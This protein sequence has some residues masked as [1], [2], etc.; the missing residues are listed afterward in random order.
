MERIHI[1]QLKT[2][3]FVAGVIDND[4]QLAIKQCGVV[5]SMEMIHALKSKGILQVV[6]D[7]EKE[8]RQTL[9]TI[10]K[11]E[12]VNV[13]NR[14][15]L[16][17]DLSSIKQLFK[18][19]SDVQRRLVEKV[20]DKKELNVEEIEQVVAKLVNAMI[21]SDEAL[22]FMTRIRKQDAYLLEHSLNVGVMLG[23]FARHLGFETNVI[24]ELVLGGVLHDIGKLMIPSKIL[25]KKGK[26]D[27][28]EY[29]IIKG[30]VVLS[31]EI[32]EAQ[33]KGIPPVSLTTLAHHHEK[34]DGSG[35]PYSL[36]EDD[37]PFFGKMIAI[38]DVFDAI[39]AKRCYKDEVVNIK[40]LAILL[41]ESGKAFDPYLVAQF[42][43]FIGT[44]PTGTLVIIEA[45]AFQKL[46]VI[47]IKNE[48]EP[49]KPRLKTFYNVKSKHYIEIESIDLA[50]INCPYKILKAVTAQ[51]YNID[52]EEL[53][54]RCF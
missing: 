28:N 23:L 5:Q 50:A 37:I 41:Q 10:E 36:T 45:G 48:Q 25:N 46:A 12:P 32:I 13:K 14:S 11:K 29:R 49:L 51:E 18:S 34:I 35:Y 15:S 53:L 1:D 44:Y 9:K 27:S 21:D 19:A 52:M 7:K 17:K 54:E 2:G 39:T 24:H 16:F 42:I 20:H 33:Y 22:W 31:R 40:A 47:E 38:V 30:H 3:M 43:K 4:R 6:V 26:L 8:I